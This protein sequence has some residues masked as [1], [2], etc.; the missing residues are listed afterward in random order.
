MYKLWLTKVDNVGLGFSVLVYI[1]MATQHHFLTSTDECVMVGG[2][3]SGSSVVFSLA[4]TANKY[5]N[6][7]YEFTTFKSEAK[8]FAEIGT[9]SRTNSNL[10]IIC[11]M[12][13]IKLPS[14]RNNRLPPVADCI[15]CFGKY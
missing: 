8:I 10:S 14:N 11:N 7:I 9:S 5:I 6:L 15:Q 13:T 2:T 4:V 1:F 12:V 3:F